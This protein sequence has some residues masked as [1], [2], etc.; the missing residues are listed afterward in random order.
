M[1]QTTINALIEHIWTIEE[2]L[3][4]SLRTLAS[5]ERTIAED[6]ED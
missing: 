4:D 1:D 3:K 2:Q 5:I 6:D